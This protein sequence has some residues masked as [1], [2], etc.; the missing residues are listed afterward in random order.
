MV[1]RM[2]SR[3]SVFVLLM[4]VVCACSKQKTAYTDVIPANATAVVSINLKSLTDKAGLNDKE[5]QALK[6][7]MMDALKSGM[8]AAA[9]EQMGK[10][11]KDPS[12]SGLDVKAPIYMFTSPDQPYTLVAKV[13]N[14]NKLQETLEFA[15][16]EQL[17]QPIAQAD[18]F[19][20][21]VIMNT[22]LAFNETTAVVTEV[23]GN[24]QVETV[25]AAIAGLMKQTAETSIAKSDG[26]Q[27]MQ[28]RKGD[29]NFFVSMESIP[30]MYARQ[31]S[32]GLPKD[33]E[34]SDLMLLGDLN[35]EKG[36]IVAHFENYT[37][38]EVLK[39]QIKK[40]EKAL[41]KLDGT[42]LKNF[43]ASTLGILSIGANGE[44]LYKLLVDNE[45]FRNQVSLTEAAEIKNL[46]HSFKGDI[47]IGLLNVGIENGTSSYGSKNAPSFV[48]YAE[49]KDGDVLKKIYENKQALNLRRGEDIVQLSD[50]NYFYKGRDM[51]MFFG[52]KGKQMYVTND[53]MTYK[54][55][56]KAA[57]SSIK[58]LD[59]TSNMKGKN[60]FFAINMD[61]VL[62][63]PIVKMIIGFG[64]EEAGMYFQL[65]SKV[66]YLECN[67]ENGTSEIVL[68]LKD[69][70]TNSL[71][72]I[73]DFVRQFAGM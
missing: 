6:Q 57:D 9:F 22:M 26:F 13:D 8:N 48:G 54:T 66:N 32:M 11:L 35:Y 2:I 56:F 4:T 41:T 15:V 52:L 21:A 51:N 69:K 10:I 67:S 25:K 45:M 58:D 18:G 71:K 65:A 55:I 29:I 12:E 5:S 14:K 37:E 7:K 40:Q 30:A 68:A 63:L 62:E 59:Y 28:N 39:E 43:P 17:S 44:E 73:V 1:R 42:F 3:L 70:N 20:Y 31:I 34:L 36:K 64:G 47:T 27:K 23:W 60:V 53:E 16:K 72:Q 38:N 61:A 50:N 19:N 49:L 46:L 33:M 24:S